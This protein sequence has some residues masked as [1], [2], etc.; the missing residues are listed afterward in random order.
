[1]YKLIFR[2]SQHIGSVVRKMVVLTFFAL[3]TVPV[4]A[5]DNPTVKFSDRNLTVSN[6]FV[7]ISKQTGFGFT[8]DQDF[9]TSR[10]V[11][12]PKNKLDLSEV[13]E[14][15][16]AGTDLEYTAYNNVVIIR[17]IQPE[18]QQLTFQPTERINAITQTLEGTVSLIGLSTPLEGTDIL[19][20]GQK[21]FSAITDAKGHFAFDAVPIGE[22][23]IRVSH[24]KYGTIQYKINVIEGKDGN[25]LIALNSKQTILIPVETPA[26]GLSENNLSSQSILDHT[27]SYA[28]IKMPR[29]AIKTNLLYDATGT[30]NLGAEFRLSNSLTLDLPFNWNPWKGKREKNKQIRHFLVQPELRYWITE[31]FN[32]HFIGFHAHYAHF[33]VSNIDLPFDFAQSIKNGRAQ[34]NLY[35]VGVSYGYQWILSNRFSLEATL[36]LGYFY[37]DYRHYGCTYCGATQGHRTKNYLGPTKV[38]LSFI[39]IIK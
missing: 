20:R 37:S 34:G 15:V 38:G 12:L 31:P 25:V 32:G 4:S 19:I 26:P 11:S 2:Q 27:T 39:Y 13:M 22:Y 5:Q 29:V 7:E 8:Y 10:E 18:I 28:P 16:L 6:I 23:M 36:G 14:I 17:S 35:G 33:N 21:T 3:V 24:P 30:F 1:M 9:N